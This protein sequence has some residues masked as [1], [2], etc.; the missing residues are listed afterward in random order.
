M[1]LKY[2]IDTIT[3]KFNS[4]KCNSKTFNLRIGVLIK[5]MAAQIAVSFAEYELLCNAKRV[6]RE[7]KE[8]KHCNAIL[9]Y[10]SKVLTIPFKEYS[11][12]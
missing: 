5:L 10:P 6:L 12:F 2:I 4:A 11:T 9:H 8:I 1:L 3:S 7:F